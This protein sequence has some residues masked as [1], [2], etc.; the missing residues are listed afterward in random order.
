M[1]VCTCIHMKRILEMCMSCTYLCVQCIGSVSNYS[2]TT[3]WNANIFESMS[4]Q[5]MFFQWHVCV[6][7][8]SII[9]TTGDVHVIEVLDE[10]TTLHACLAKNN[11]P[12]NAGWIHFISKY[13]GMH[14][15]LLLDRMHNNTR[16]VT[17]LCICLPHHCTNPLYTSSLGSHGF[18]AEAWM[19]YP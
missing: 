2:Y 10:C 3:A 7:F 5:A 9:N 8:N 18:H 13:V 1:H 6:D 14:V 19:Y 16:N 12:D 4:A 11:W 15:S 17:V